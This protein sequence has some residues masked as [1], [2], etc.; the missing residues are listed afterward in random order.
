MARKADT[1]HVSDDKIR[2]LLQQYECPVAFHVVRTRFLGSIAS[3]NAGVS[4][5]N[6][7]KALWDGE[8]PPFDSLDAANEF[9]GVLLNGLWNQLTRHHERSAAFRLVRI[10]VPVSRAGLASLTRWRRDE[11]DGFLEGLFG[12]EDRIDL[13]ERAHTA[14]KELGQLRMIIEGARELADD[15]TKTV[16]VGE[17]RKTFA[18]FRDLTRIAEHEMHEVVLACTRA[19][20]QLLDGAPATR[21]IMH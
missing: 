12:D 10:D 20:R 16:E 3:P 15:E 21:P 6:T 17:L 9:L 5:M 19:R 13:P 4:P 7:V 14:L 8:L 18:H 1:T 2:K 11:L